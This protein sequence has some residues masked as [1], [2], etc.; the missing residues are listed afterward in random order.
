[1]K[2]SENF[3]L[4][5]YVHPVIF[6]RFGKDSKLYINPQ[7]FILVQEIR[8]KWGQSITINNWNSGGRYI[9][10]GLRDYKNPLGTLNRSR[11]YYG[12][13]ADLK[14]KDIRGLQQHIADN[15]EYYYNFGLRVI[16]D[17]DY[18]SSW[19]HVSVENTGLGEI[20]YIKP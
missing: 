14:T 9:N 16:E 12:L 10:S 15:S 3:E 2:I 7:L 4:Q 11:H 6:K 19:C 5:E 18:T 20:R 17:F 1:M 8:T 13:C